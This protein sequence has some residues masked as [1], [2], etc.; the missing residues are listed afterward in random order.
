MGLRAPSAARLVLRQPSLSESQSLALHTTR[1]AHSG[2]WEQQFIG[3]RSPAHLDPHL[4]GIE[5]EEDEDEEL[6]GEAERREG[7]KLVSE[8]EEPCNHIPSPF[9]PT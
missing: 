1:S 8:E 3:L 5:G 4:G 2:Q 7:L 9:L 6:A